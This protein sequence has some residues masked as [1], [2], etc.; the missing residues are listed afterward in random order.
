ME[1]P[2]TP[3]TPVAHDEWLPVALDD[4]ELQPTRVDAT[5]RSAAEAAVRARSPPRAAALVALP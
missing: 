5:T 2:V 3:G 4:E 1:S